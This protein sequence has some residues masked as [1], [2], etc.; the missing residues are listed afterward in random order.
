MSLEDTYRIIGLET[1]YLMSD[2]DK[3]MPHTVGAV[4]QPGAVLFFDFRDPDLPSERQVGYTWEVIETGVVH[5][6]AF[7]FRLDLDDV[8]SLSTAPDNATTCWKQAVQFR[9]LPSVTCSRV[10]VL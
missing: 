1:S 5:A 2:T 10:H 9:E 6:V 8:E 7:W 3:T 4:T